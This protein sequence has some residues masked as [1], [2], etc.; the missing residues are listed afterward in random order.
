MYVQLVQVSIVCSVGTG[1][2]FMF[3]RYKH[4][5]YVQSVQA[6]IVWSVGTSRYCM[7]SRYR[8]VLYVQSVQYLFFL[9]ERWPEWYRQ[10]LS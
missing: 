7:F 9:C 3:S 4:V 10:L 1:E 6:G 5:L 2:Y 8:Q